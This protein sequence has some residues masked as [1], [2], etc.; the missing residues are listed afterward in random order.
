MR[1][2]VHTKICFDRACSSSHRRETPYVRALFKG[3]CCFPSQSITLTLRAA[4]QRF[5]FPCKT[6]PHT[7]WKATLQMPICGLS[8]DVHSK[9]DL[10][11]TPEPPYW[12]RGRGC[13]SNR[14]GPC[15]ANFWKRSK[16]RVRRRYLFRYGLCPIHTFPQPAYR[17]HV[18]FEWNPPD[19]SAE[20]SD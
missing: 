5:K 9:N 11:P 12:Y 18:A 20:S 7:L 16:N 6:S 1:Q 19:A 3:R 10:D 17:L 13:C 15:I 14:G 8:K 4:L 2:T